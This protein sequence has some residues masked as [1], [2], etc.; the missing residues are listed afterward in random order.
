VARLPTSPIN[1]G[2]GFPLG[3]TVKGSGH[4]AFDLEFVP[5]IQASPRKTTVTVHPGLL[6]GIGHG[7]T[8]G[9]RLAFD[10]DP[11]QFGFTPLPNKSWPIGKSNTGEKS[12]GGFFKSYF[13]EAVPAGSVQP[14]DWRPQ[15]ESGYVWPAFWR[16]LLN[17][18]ETSA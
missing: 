12:N 10:V 4:L 1:F 6:Y 9:M 14:A 18:V 15:H 7:F 3:I 13:V 8:A 17:L 16:G 2:I 11:S 5:F